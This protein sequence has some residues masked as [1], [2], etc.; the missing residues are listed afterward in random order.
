MLVDRRKE[1]NDDLS[2]DPDLPPCDILPGSKGTD[3]ETQFN[4]GT[5]PP[6]TN[7][8]QEV[9]MTRAIVERSGTPV[10]CPKSL[11]KSGTELQEETISAMQMTAL[12]STELQTYDEWTL[13]PQRNGKGGTKQAP[14]G[15]KEQKVGPKTPKV[16]PK[17]GAKRNDLTTK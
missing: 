16:R 1:R 12:L 17:V 6:A 5:S 4:T 8:G 14:N 11:H 9:S 2:H 3:G 15:P 7:D 13:I 10:V